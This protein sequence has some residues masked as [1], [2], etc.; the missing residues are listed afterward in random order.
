M[1][2]IQGPASTDERLGPEP[3]TKAG[4]SEAGRSRLGDL[5][6][7]LAVTGSSRRRQTRRAPP[8][9]DLF[10]PSRVCGWAGWKA[11]FG[12]HWQ[13]KRPPPVSGPPVAVRWRG[14]YATSADR[15]HSG[16]VPLSAL[17][18]DSIGMAPLLA[19][20]HGATVAAAVKESEELYWAA[21]YADAAPLPGRQELLFPD[22]DALSAWVQQECRPGEVA[23]LHASPEILKRVQVSIDV[24]ELR[25][26]PPVHPELV[27][28]LELRALP[29]V[30]RATGRAVLAGGVLLAGWT[31][32]D[33]FYF[34]RLERQDSVRM[35]AYE[36][37][38]DLFL[39][40]C[41]D[42][43]RKAWPVPPGWE[44]ESTGCTTGGMDDPYVL[45]VPFEG[46]SAYRK[47]SLAA[48]HDGTLAR[49]AAKQLLV[50]WDGWWN[51]AETSILLQRRVDVPL[52]PAGAAPQTVFSELRVQAEAMFIGLADE[53]RTE[54]STISIVSSASIPTVVRRLI[55]LHR[56]QPISLD[57]FTRGRQGLEVILAPRRTI[58]LPEASA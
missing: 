2:I 41:H 43:L 40:N 3:L 57:R 4:T 14:L 47:F 13:G 37:P 51:V 26:R 15:L 8:E 24:S 53:I 45:Q 46:G 25:E 55:E 28:A 17:I 7:K 34:S 39:A 30:V 49:A 33:H 12:L 23:R 36:A 16:M 52:Q 38:V 20:W 50:G 19:E 56:R 11:V 6:R 44:T 31:A 27:P 48:G 21:I 18:A 32:A 1:T 54:R 35:V 9:A 58:M 42:Q 22:L 5:L 10:Q 29:R